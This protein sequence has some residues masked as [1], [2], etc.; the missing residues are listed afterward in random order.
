MSA[1]KRQRV[2]DTIKRAAEQHSLR[3]D[4]AVRLRPS[5]NNSVQDM[6]AQ[7]LKQNATIML[8]GSNEYSIAPNNRYQSTKKVEKPL[9]QSMAVLSVKELTKMKHDDSMSTISNGNKEPNYLS[10]SFHNVRKSGD[11]N[12]RDSQSSLK[13]LEKAE[14]LNKAD[15]HI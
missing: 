15:L 11:S 14:A 3:G 2:L 5:L 4:L 6:R 1:E 7:L 12:L 10:Q 8:G 9:S 13:L